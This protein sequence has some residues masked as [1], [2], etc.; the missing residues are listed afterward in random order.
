MSIKK[1][2][3]ISSL[4]E[5]YELKYLIPFEMIEPISEFAS[6]YCSPDNYSSMTASGFYRVN[7]LYLD[8]PTY[9]FLKMRLE[10]VQNRINMRVRSYGDNPVPPYF[11]EIKQ[12]TGGV[13]RKYRAPVM[14]KHWYRSYTEPGFHGKDGQGDDVTNLNRKRFERLVYTYNAE[15]KILTQYLRKALIS[16]V[17]DYARIT[18]DT[19]LRYRPE[20]EFLPV[21]NEREMTSSD[22]SLAFDPGCSVI[23]ELKCYTSRVPLWMIDLIR[24]FNLQRQSFSKYMLGASELMGLYRYDSGSRASPCRGPNF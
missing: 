3:T 10:G 15:P 24:F 23:L 20:T 12:K 1:Q 17:D 8:S 4:L 14:D 9:H 16:D 22:H 21:P 13:V 11:L 19:N 5:R 7:S 2:K 6:V 18:F